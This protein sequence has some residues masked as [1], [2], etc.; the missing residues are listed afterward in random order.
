MGLCNRL[1]HQCLSDGHQL[2]VSAFQGP[3]K[4]LKTHEREKKKKYLKPCLEQHHHFT[5]VIVSTNGLIG[6]EATTL[7]KRLAALIAEKSGKSY[8]EVCGYVNAHMSIAII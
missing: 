4:V 3:L 2:Q 7:L 1:H 8:S 6:R 5:P